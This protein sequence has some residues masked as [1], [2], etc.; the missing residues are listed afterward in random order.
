MRMMA[1]AGFGDK[2]NVS[3]HFAVAAG[4]QAGI[5]FPRNHIV[6]IAVNMQ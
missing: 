4:D 3:A 2:L 6:R 1:D 5:L